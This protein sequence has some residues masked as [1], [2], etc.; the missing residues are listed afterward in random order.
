MAEG[1]D[2]RRGATVSDTESDQGGQ[3]A[4]VGHDVE[5]HA[6]QR[7]AKRLDWSTLEKVPDQRWFR[8][9]IVFTTIARVIVT[10]IRFVH[11]L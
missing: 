4:T 8:M 9:V 1:A 3:E 7:D 11:D 5:E 10:V 6:T 2:S